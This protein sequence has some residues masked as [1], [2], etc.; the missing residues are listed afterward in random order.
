MLNIRR[1]AGFGAVHPRG[2]RRR[3][4]LPR[5]PRRGTA[6]RAHTRR[7]GPCG[8]AVRV[9][10]R[11]RDGDRGRLGDAEQRESFQARR[12]DD[13]L[14]IAD[15]HVDRR[16]ADV[17]V[18]EPAASLVIAD[19]GVPIAELLQPMAPDRALPVEL[20]M[21]QP[22]RDPHQ[23]RT[24]SVQR[25]SKAHAVPSRAEADVLLHR[26]TVQLT[27]GD[28]EAARGAV[29]SVRIRSPAPGSA[30]S[31]VL[32]LRGQGGHDRV[33]PAE[34]SARQAAGRAPRQASQPA[35]GAARLSPGRGDR[36]GAEAGPGR[37]RPRR[38][39]PGPGRSCRGPRPG[40]SAAG[41]PRRPAAAGPARRARSGRL[42]PPGWL[43]PAPLGG[44]QAAQRAGIAGRGELQGP[45]RQIGCC[46]RGR[47]QDLRR[48]L[49]ESGQRGKITGV[50]GL[51][52]VPGGERR[53]SAA[54]QQDLCVL[55]VQRLD[56][57]AA[58]S[59]R[60]RRGGPARAGTRR[61]HQP[62][63]PAPRPSP[64]EPRAAAWPG[65]GRACQRHLPAGTTIRGRPRSPAGAGPG[66]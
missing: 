58:G 36:R 65:P 15:P 20:Q 29:D 8:N 19:D 27:L 45:R 11:V 9:S 38:R 18:R 32:S 54:V 35:P 44:D 39:R 7:T 48:R 46:L 40:R 51:E 28:R 66:R 47:R 31:A 13:R 5:C 43:L 59:S 16:I 57:V 41:P 55:A 60:R 42:A 34:D 63:S 1:N 22:G 61:R 30:E 14:E 53:R 6:G 26:L 3:W 23:R 21:S 2:S 37:G 4:P 33:I 12:I 17:G 25:V 64:P 24:A 52:Q 62:G 10:C 49:V 56:G 50:R